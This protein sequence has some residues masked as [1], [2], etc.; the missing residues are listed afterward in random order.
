MRDK[1]ITRKVKVEGG[2]LDFSSAHFVTYSGKCERLHGH[3]Y[4][5]LVEVE[6]ELDDDKIVVDFTVL[7]RITKAICRQ[8][9]HRFLLPLHNPHLNITSATDTWKIC[10]NEKCYIFPRDDV[11]ELPIEN[12]TAEQ[13]AEYIGE[14]LYRTLA[15]EDA[16]AL[17]RM[18]VLL[19][20]VAETPM[21]MAFYRRQLQQNRS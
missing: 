8:L 5:V 9:D 16:R 15:V 3:N 20:G 21:Q 10:F 14:E 2:Y 19:V 11:V 7:K 1:Y 6:G 17:T 13:L 12:T 4:T 18:H